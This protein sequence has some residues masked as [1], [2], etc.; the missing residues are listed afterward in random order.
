MR[1]SENRQKGNRLPLQYMENDPQK[2]AAFE[3]LVET[4]IRDYRKRQNLLKKN[5][6]DEDKSGFRRRNLNDTQ[7]ITRT[8]YNL[9]R[10]YLEF[11]PSIYH[12]KEQ[13]MAVNGAVTDYMRKR[14]GL[15]KNRADGDKHHAMDA[16]VIAVTTDAMI[17]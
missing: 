7:Y 15:H 14:F 2:A 10:D 6:T 11:A 16:A 17:Q 3:T 8:V 13:I 12:G 5:L 9:F 4:R 1:S